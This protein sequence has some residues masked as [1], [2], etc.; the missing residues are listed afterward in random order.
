MTEAA[1]DPVQIRQYP[2][3]RAKPGAGR[4]KSSPTSTKE[5]RNAKLMPPNAVV[6]LVLDELDRRRLRFVQHADEHNP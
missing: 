2:R 3:S 5:R 1:R 6:D 4:P